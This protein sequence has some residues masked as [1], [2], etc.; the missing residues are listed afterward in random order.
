ML[1]SSLGHCF[2]G[3]CVKGTLAPRGLRVSTVAQPSIQVMIGSVVRDGSSYLATLLFVS[4]SLVF[5]RRVPFLSSLRSHTLRN[6]DSTH[7]Q[8]YHHQTILRIWRRS[9]ASLFHL[10]CSVVTPSAVVAD[11]PAV[12]LFR[13]GGKNGKVLETQAESARSAGKAS[14]HQGKE[15]AA[16]GEGQNQEG[17]HKNIKELKFASSSSYTGHCY[18]PSLF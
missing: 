14:G 8:L 1:R 6:S 18:W 16:G 13:V 7:T 10:P 3:Q 9:Y 15:A 2:R 11:L 4:Y 17:K 12:S 5:G